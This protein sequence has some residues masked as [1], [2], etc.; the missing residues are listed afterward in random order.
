M[1]KVA[2]C[3]FWA[4]PNTSPRNEW[5]IMIWSET[6]TAY[7]GIPFA[8]WFHRHSGSAGRPGCC[9]FWNTAGKLAGK[10]ANGMAGASKNV[11]HR[12]RKQRKRGREASPVAP[13]RAMGRRDFADLARNQPQAAA[14]E[15][16][17][18]RRRDVA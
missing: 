6:S 10:S 7:T 2:P 3:T 8:S 18:E 14:V 15:R 13:A 4:G 11:E 1:T 12:I 9:P 17:A 5:A 16:F